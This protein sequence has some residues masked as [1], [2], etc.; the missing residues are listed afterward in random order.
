MWHLKTTTEIVIVGALYIVKKNTDKYTNKIS[1][2]PSLCE[3]QKKMQL[4]KLLI[5]LGE[6]YQCDW[7]SNTREYG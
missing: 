5:S 6:Y 7:K 2:S 4:A 3:I 1:G